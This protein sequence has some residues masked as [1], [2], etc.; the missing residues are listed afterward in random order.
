[1][2]RRPCRERIL[3]ETVLSP[4]QRRSKGFIMHAERAVALRGIGGGEIDEFD[5]G[6]VLVPLVAD[7]FLGDVALRRLLGPLR[8]ELALPVFYREAFA[9]IVHQAGVAGVVPAVLLILQFDF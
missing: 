9:H 8:D 3:A 1:Y 7:Q 4:Y 6:V 2:L 5:G